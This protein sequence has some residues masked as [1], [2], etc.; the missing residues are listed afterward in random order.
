[1]I[2]EKNSKKGDMNRVKLGVTGKITSIVMVIIFLSV[3]LLSAI[4]YKSSYNQV[5]QAAGLELIGC[6]NITTGII[7]IDKLTQLMSGDRSVLSKIEEDI[8]WTVTKKPI[9][10][11]HYILSMDGKILAADEHLQKQGFKAGDDFFV[12]KIALDRVINMK[13]GEYTEIYKFGGMDRLTG[14]APIFEDHD[15]NKKVIA[16]NAID[17]NANIIKDRTWEMARTTI[18]IGILLPF[19]AALITLLIVRKMIKPVIQISEHVKEVASGQLNIKPLAFKNKD[20]IGQLSENF[21]SMTNS[22]KKIIENVSN[23]S[24]Q[25]VTTSQ[26]LSVSTEE[27][28]RATNN[29]SN[30]IQDV[31][32]GME[33]QMKH[34]VQ[35]KNEMTTI[36][37]T[38]EHVE[39]VIHRAMAVSNEA[40]E[41]AQAGNENVDR[42]IQQMTVIGTN[43]STMNET[44]YTLNSKT[45]EINQI[46]TLITA[47]SEQTNLLALN[48]AIEAARAGE[49]GKGFAIV[50]DE[51]R[52]LA[53]ES[54]RATEQINI[55]INEIQTEVQKSVK[56]IDD[57]TVAAKEGIEIVNKTSESFKKILQTTSVSEKSLTIVTEQ[58]VNI[59]NEF[60]QMIKLITEVANIST[61]TAENTEEITASSQEQTAVMQELADAS[62][63]LAIMAENLQKAI[64]I[65]K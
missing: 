63:E 21:T 47:V 19:I 10:E 25:L 2:K 48:A 14:Y 16:I 44:I 3:G 30:S 56:A 22:L 27:S 43:T 57:G 1:M 33:H 38:I 12:D 50:A 8:N 54:A 32:L 52:K 26:Q 39:N 46:L 11:T 41:T 13:H 60:Q 53:D 49:H 58:M 36:S 37:D 45:K 20:E 5:L 6:A 62:Q 65:F 31:A 28:T 59:R 9:F 18:L 61:K 34:I 55:L 64:S 7:D 15:P 42:V 24:K 29:I 40:A 4:N 51:V 23:S 35:T 17:F